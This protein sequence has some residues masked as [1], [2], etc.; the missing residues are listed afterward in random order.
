MPSMRRIPCAFWTPRIFSVRTDPD[1]RS[2]TSGRTNGVGTFPNRGQIFFD[3][4]QARSLELPGIL[5]LGRRARGAAYQMWFTE[6]PA[7]LCS[8]GPTLR[9][10]EFALLQL[11]QSF[12][13]QDI[14][15]A[16]SAGYLLREMAVHAIHDYIVDECTRTTGVPPR[17][18]VTDLL[19]SIIQI[20][21]T[22]EEG[23]WARGLLGFVE[24]S[25][26]HQVKFLACFPK[27]ER[28]HLENFKHVRKLLQAVERSPQT[29]V[30][31]GEFI[32]GIAVNE[33]PA[34]SLHCEFRGRHGMLVL[35]GMPVCSF[36]DGA[37]HG[38]NRKPKL[39]MLEEALEGWPLTLERR[40][41]LFRSITRIVEAAGEEK[42]GCTI[43]VDPGNP[44]LRLP[45][46][47]LDMPIDLEPDEN[48]RL[49]AGLSKVDGAL[50]MDRNLKL[51]AFA[52]LMDGPALPVE[53]RARGARY[54]SALRFTAQHPGLVVIV[55][56]F[57]RPVSVIQNGKDF[58]RPP[59]WPPIPGTLRVPPTVFHWLSA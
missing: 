15:S 44:P 45:G 49:A 17:F 29:L 27:T 51:R 32:F 56:S 4:S 50:H 36:S 40:Y 5:S 12:V 9:W 47:T 26:I 35:D 57:D 39:I 20:S 2:T 52:C 48:L 7:D 58:T 46:Q 25:R 53:D 3:E 30:S 11:S 43:V 18:R 38:N 13:I 28:P 31:D 10:L 1:W 42:Y 41:K 34:P 59:V 6:H 24:P 22:P 21:K 33:L 23:A 55:V 16:E 19:E 8:A 54:N 37:F 14:L